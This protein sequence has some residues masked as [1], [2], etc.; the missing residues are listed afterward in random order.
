MY[1][2]NRLHIEIQT[3]SV[4]HIE[5]SQF[6]NRIV[7]I[8][9]IILLKIPVL[10]QSYNHTDLFYVLKSMP[11]SSKNSSKHKKAAL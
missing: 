10:K 3:Y 7:Q 9:F 5:I 8:P 6:S 2:K 1:V 4:F 11:F